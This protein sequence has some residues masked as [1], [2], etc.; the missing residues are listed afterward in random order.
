M[1]IQTLSIIAGSEACNARCP[2]CISRMTPPHGVE[3]REPEVNWRNFDLACR[4]AARC[5]VTTAMVTGKGEPTL[6]P[7]Q[8]TKFLGALAPHGFPFVELQ[9]NGIL[10]SERKRDYR[11]VLEEWYRLGLTTLAISIVDHR[12]EK[13]HAIYTPHRQTYIDLP[14]LIG[15][16]HGMGFSV[17]LAA[18]LLNDFIDSPAELWSLIEFASDLGVE[19]LTVR[20]VNRP[21]HAADPDVA[22]W[23]DAHRL[24]PER[25]EVIR[26]WLDSAGVLVMTLVHG[27]LVYDVEGQNVCL[28][29]SLT[30]APSTEDVRQLIFFP[31]G[32]LRYD[33][34]RKGA[35]L[36]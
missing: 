34:Q 4:L 9:T 11:P 35:I 3:L 20:P 6:Y 26:Q 36:L 32:H 1:R 17:R 13:N 30:L 29:D 25:L 16:L 21:F 23:T 7:A 19:Q 22:A 31:D 8:I 18:I 15:R 2:F 27:A 24:P 12:P 14:E 28:T 33:W 10:F 5:G